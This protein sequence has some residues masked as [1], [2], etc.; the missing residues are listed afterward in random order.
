MRLFSKMNGE[1][2]EYIINSNGEVVANSV[3]RENGYNLYNI[4]NTLEDKNNQQTSTGK[5][6]IKNF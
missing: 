6:K 5:L 1:G 3:N 2:Y 4:I